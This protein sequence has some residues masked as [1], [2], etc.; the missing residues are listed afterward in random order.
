M[1]TDFNLPDFRQICF[2]NDKRVLLVKLTRNRLADG[3]GGIYNYSIRVEVRPFKKSFPIYSLYSPGHSI[4]E[5]FA[6]IR[7]QLSASMLLTSHNF[8]S[9]L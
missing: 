9:T 7:N 2:C 3:K 8:R 6:Q 5:C 1:K 4:R